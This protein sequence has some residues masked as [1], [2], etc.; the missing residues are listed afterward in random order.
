M[1]SISSVSGRAG[2]R[3]QRSPDAFGREAPD[4]I[5]PPVA[6]IDVPRGIDGDIIRQ[7]SVRNAGEA[8]QLTHRGEGIDGRIRAALPGADG[9]I[10]DI[11]RAIRAQV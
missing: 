1:G 3:H 10:E 9:A 11:E 6:D 7:L 2:G 4:D 5:Q 8:Y